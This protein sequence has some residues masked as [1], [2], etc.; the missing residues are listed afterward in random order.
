M[1]SGHIFEELQNHAENALRKV[2]DLQ[3]LKN[4]NTWEEKT[5]INIILKI[6]LTFF[7]FNSQHFIGFI[8]ISDFVFNSHLVQAAISK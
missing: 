5:K 2:K 3:E 1:D 8:K 6:K 4:N 7:Y